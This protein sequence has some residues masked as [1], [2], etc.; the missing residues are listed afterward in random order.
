MN[1][2]ILYGNAGEPVVNN[3]SLHFSLWFLDGNMQADDLYYA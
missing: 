1:N 2:M 3:L